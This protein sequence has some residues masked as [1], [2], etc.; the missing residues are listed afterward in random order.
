[1]TAKGKG[2]EY[3]NAHYDK[4]REY[5]RRYYEKTKQ[6]RKE[7]YNSDPEYKNKLITRSKENKYG[8]KEGEYKVLLEVQNGVCAICKRP[9]VSSKTN[10]LFIDH[11][12]ITGKVRG[13]LC[14]KCNVTIG[15]VE[16]DV[17]RLQKIIEYLDS[18]KS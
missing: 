9:Q 6:A 5:E 1:M 2:T 17:S 3:R 8:L 15:M 18:H 10:N 4:V 11:N 7:K 14:N 13:L 16:E 12:H